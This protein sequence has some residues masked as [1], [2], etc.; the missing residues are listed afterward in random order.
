[1]SLLTAVLVLYGAGTSAF[2]L[3]NL[4][5]QVDETLSQDVETVETLLFLEPDGRI[6][7]QAQDTDEDEGGRLLEVW[8]PDGPLLY[9]SPQ[10]R[11]RAL[12]A[13]PDGHEGVK[14]ARLADGTR[15]RIVN[16]MH[17]IG[18]RPVVVRLA[19]S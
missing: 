4:R 16:R 12:G 5:E 2:F 6:R 14:G 18:T 13:A 11:G 7:V 19:V 1:V 8:S 3:R 10:L 15:V 9:R 17:R